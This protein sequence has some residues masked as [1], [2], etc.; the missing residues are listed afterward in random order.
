MQKPKKTRIWKLKKIKKEFK[1]LKPE[2]RAALDNF[3]DGNGKLRNINKPLLRYIGD[4]AW[5]AQMP[6]SVFLEKNGYK[7]EHMNGRTDRLLDKTIVDMKKKI[8]DYLAKY[9]DLIDL[10]HY[11]MK[12]YKMIEKHANWNYDIS[13]SAFLKQLGYEY[14]PNPRKIRTE[15]ELKS[16]LRVQKIKYG[17]LVNLRLKDKT[18]Y[19]KLMSFARVRFGKEG[20]WK[21]ALEFLGFENE[22]ILHRRKQKNPFLKS[23]FDENTIR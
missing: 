6:T 7:Y 18:V 10:T 12:L 22:N 5:R 15:E 13:V 23:S 9:G 1:F 11:D 4:R 17:S 21:A 3:V 2:I 14:F 19:R 16:K 8:D 20:N